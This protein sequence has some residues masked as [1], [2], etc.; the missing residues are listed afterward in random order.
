MVMRWLLCVPCDVSG[1]SGQNLHFVLLPGWNDAHVWPERS[2]YSK[3]V[4]TRTVAR[5]PALGCTH[6]AVRQ[7]Y[8]CCCCFFVSHYTLHCAPTDFSHQRTASPA[9]CS[10]RRPCPRTCLQ[11]PRTRYWNQPFFLILFVVLRY[12]N[13]FR[14]HVAGAPPGG[15]GSSL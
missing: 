4:S 3:R 8:C 1:F 14:I 7:C 11:S 2:C 5:W 15:S 13:T 9:G 12:L 6:C 10:L